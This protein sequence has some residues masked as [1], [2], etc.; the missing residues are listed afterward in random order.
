MGPS[1]F[2]PTSA[3]NVPASGPTGESF[4]IRKGGNAVEFHGT[5]YSFANTFS[6]KVDQ[7]VVPLGAQGEHMRLRISHYCTFA[8]QRMGDSGDAFRLTVIWSI[9]KWV[10]DPAF[11]NAQ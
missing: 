5:K 4:V 9:K 11:L 1:A 2:P 3:P 6:V 7:T 8:V 10:A